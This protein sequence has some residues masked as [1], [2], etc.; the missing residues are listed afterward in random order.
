MAFAASDYTKINIG[1]GWRRVFGT[2]TEAALAGSGITTGLSY[3]REAGASSDTG[4][5]RTSISGGTLTI[6]AEND[7]TDDG[8]WYAIG[9]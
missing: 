7:G 4:N 3:I 2:F 1:G 5:V 9:R 8:T 6:I